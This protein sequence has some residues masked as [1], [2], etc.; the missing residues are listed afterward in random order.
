MKNIGFDAARQEGKRVRA[1]VRAFTH[2]CFS[3]RRKKTRAQ[4]VTEGERENTGFVAGMHID[5]RKSIFPIRG[6]SA[7]GGGGH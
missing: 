4:I 2:R 6:P 5:E 7:K 3:R 1:R